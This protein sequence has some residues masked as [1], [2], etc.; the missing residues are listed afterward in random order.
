MNC[1]GLNRKFDAI[2]KQTDPDKRA[3]MTWR[4][5]AFVA[6][7]S[8]RCKVFMKNKNLVS[9]YLFTLMR[10]IEPDP[11]PV[12][13]LDQRARAFVQAELANFL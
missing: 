11:S 6:R 12:P 9:S 13:D 10:V 7:A 4:L 5:M 1:R 2:L 3:V 8:T